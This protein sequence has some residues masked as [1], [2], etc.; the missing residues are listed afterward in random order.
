MVLKSKGTPLLMYSL[1]FKAHKMLDRSTSL[2]EFF[3]QAMLRLIVG[4][5]GN[6]VFDPE[7]TLLQRLGTTLKICKKEFPYYMFPYWWNLQEEPTVVCLRDGREDSKLQ[8]S[9]E[10]S[11][12]LMLGAEGVQCLLFLSSQIQKEHSIENFLSFLII[13]LTRVLLNLIS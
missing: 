13:F 11:L 3:F 4:N 7:G 1:C 5:T 2:I 6:S 9:Y 10:G 12:S 8:V